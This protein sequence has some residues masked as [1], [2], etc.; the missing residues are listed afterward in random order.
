MQPPDSRREPATLARLLAYKT[1]ALV[2]GV[3]LLA[4]A[5]L[6]GLQ[7][8]RR[9]YQAALD[10]YSQLRG[11][12][13]TGI[14]AAAARDAL[15]VAPN[16]RA[17]AA[18]H[19]ESAL[20]R[21]SLLSQRLAPSGNGPDSAAMQ[22][23]SHLQWALAEL[24]G[25]E[26]GPDASSRAQTSILRALGELSNLGQEI[27]QDISR[28][29]RDSADRLQA[30]LAV[31]VGASLLMIVG[32]VV[33]EAWQYRRVMRPLRRLGEGVRDLAAGRLDRRLAV[34]GDREFRRLAED[35]NDMA[36]ELDGLYRQLEQRVAD[37][38]RELVQSERLASVGFLAAGVAHE[39]NN[40]LAIVTG[41]A[42]LALRQ[43]DRSHGPEQV[44]LAIAEAT[45]A[46]RV[47]RD[48]AFRCKEIT[49]KLL[50]LSRPGSDRRAPV[51]LVLVATDVAIMVR[52]LQKY[53]DRRVTLRFDAAE[54]V[55]VLANATEMRQVV[56]NLTVNAL[57]AVPAGGEVVIAGSTR[58]A[59]A[60]QGPWSELVVEDN[61]RGMTEQTLARVFEPFFTDK[62][63]VGEPGTGLGLSITHAIITGHGGRI[64][65]S[66]AGPGKGSRFV[67]ELPALSEGLATE[68]GLGVAAREV[69]VPAANS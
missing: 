66:S 33:V 6:W 12:Y 3:A 45:E 32:A 62:R 55:R 50:E 9:D 23:E 48:E 61:G 40:P 68:T 67:V 14:A 24:R 47:I 36:G 5:M 15:D 11:V 38:S 65:A 42:E 52:R 34:E 10:Q 18:R 19:V 51:D 27:R 37:K 59:R 1:A 35:F 30:T 56:L 31:L 57:E 7:G 60:G 69:P 63:G 46:L 25:R 49:H 53:A 26:S 54:R 39:I 8:L 13:E 4:G 28:I 22:V 21:V 58:Q 64:T 43:L 2:L 17:R 20:G 29:D 41:H 44:T 16:D